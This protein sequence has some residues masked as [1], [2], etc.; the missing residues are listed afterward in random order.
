MTLSCGQNLCP[1]PG[2]AQLAR[3]FLNAS[4]LLFMSTVWAG[5]PYLTNLVA[6]RITN[7]QTVTISF[8]I[9]GGTNDIPL[10]MYQASNPGQNLWPFLG[11]GFAS[12]TYTFSNQPSARAFYTLG[13]PPVTM[14]VAWGDDFSARP[15]CLSP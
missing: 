3:V 15:T 1:R 12:N 9:S 11:V 4:F 5:T 14:A 8:R 13:P 2:I 6:T 10:N 7:N